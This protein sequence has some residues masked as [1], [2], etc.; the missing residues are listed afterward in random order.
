[1]GHITTEE[2]HDNLCLFMIDFT[3][4]TRNKEIFGHV[5]IESLRR[6]S[7]NITTLSSNLKEYGGLGNNEKKTELKKSFTVLF[8]I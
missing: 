4:N 3:T 8:S 5:N 1:M 6:H 2:Y 7:V